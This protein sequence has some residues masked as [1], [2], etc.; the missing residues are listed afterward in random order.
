[1]LCSPSDA[2]LWSWQ[3][4]DAAGSQLRWMRR[5]TRARRASSVLALHKSS[6]RLWD[7]NTWNVAANIPRRKK[8]REEEVESASA[9]ASL[10]GEADGSS[11]LM[12]SKKTQSQTRKK[13]VDRRATHHLDGDSIA[14]T[15]TTTKNSGNK[16]AGM[17]THHSDA[18]GEINQHKIK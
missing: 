10:T 3:W 16:S 2:V 4:C 17:L 1:M 13:G 15:T 18:A 5:I 14:K 7:G 8:E 11:P 6:P 12:S 9:C